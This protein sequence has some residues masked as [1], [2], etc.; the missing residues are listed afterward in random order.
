MGEFVPKIT[1]EHSDYHIDHPESEEELDR[2]LDR[3][4]EE[5]MREDPEERE[6]IRQSVEKLSAGT[7][8]IAERMDRVEFLEDLSHEEEIGEENYAD[9]EMAETLKEMR[10][11]LEAAKKE[12]EANSKPE[13]KWSTAKRFMAIAAGIGAIGAGIFALIR[14]FL[15]KS[16]GQDPSQDPDLKDISEDT[17]TILE[18]MYQDWARKSPAEFFNGLAAKVRKDASLSVGDQIYFMDMV[19]KLKALMTPFLWDSVADKIEM[20]DRFSGAWI[21]A[22]ADVP[23]NEKVARLYEAAGVE[24]Y[25]DDPVPIKIMAGVL[26]LVFARIGFDPKYK[27]G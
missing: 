2:E 13:S 22:G 11:F 9:D 20:V 17:L 26:R 19:V 6:R 14:Y 16:K 8:E 1:P 7:A 4:F 12:R 3:D 23:N 5:E 21:A 10:E 24:K 27:E 18:G 15:L 25:L